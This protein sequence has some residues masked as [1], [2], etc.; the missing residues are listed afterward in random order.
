MAN[1]TTLAKLLGK[2]FAAFPAFAYLHSIAQQL[3]NVSNKYSWS[4]CLCGGDGTTLQSYK[5][6][7]DSECN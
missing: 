3:G 6:M 5:C 1:L 4:Y 2:W 7:A